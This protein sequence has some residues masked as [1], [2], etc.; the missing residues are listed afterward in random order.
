MKLPGSNMKMVSPDEPVTFSM[1]EMCFA[2]GS[3]VAVCILWV[4]SRFQTKQAALASEQELKQHI[5][6]VEA[7]VEKMRTDI[8][9]IRADV[10]YIRGRLEPKA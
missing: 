9:G 6:K 1:I 7:D 5:L 3:A 2:V 4:F 10:S 8:T